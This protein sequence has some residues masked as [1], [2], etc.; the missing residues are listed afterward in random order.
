MT[1]PQP[2]P[3]PPASPCTRCQEEARAAFRGDRLAQLLAQWAG[4]SLIYVSE[5]QHETEGPPQ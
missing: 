4:A 1:T 5:C 2:N 3:A